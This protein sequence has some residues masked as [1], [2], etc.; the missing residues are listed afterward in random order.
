M[1]VK[2][3]LYV[4][5]MFFTVTKSSAVSAQ[6]KGISVHDP[7]I[8]KE[9]NT[10]HIFCTG[11]GI[12]H[13]YSGDLTHWI[14]GKPVFKKVPAWTQKVVPG[15]N[16]R[17]WAP[18]VSYYDGKYYLFYAVS[19]FG[20]NASAIGLAT[21]STLNE[22]SPEY[23]WKDQGIIV[24]SVPRRDMWNA[25]DPNLVVDNKGNPWLDF[26]SFWSG[27]KLVQLK[28]NRMGI[29][30]PQKWA[31]IASRKRKFG[32]ADT[33]PGNAAIEAPYIIHHGGYYYLFVSY[34]Y[35]CRGIKRNYK[36]MVGRAKEVTGPYTDKKGVPMTKG[37]AAVL[38]TGDRR[39]PGL[40]HNAVL[41]DHGK[42]Y[43]VFHAY[44]ARENG[45]PKL[46]ILPVS[47]E[48]GWPEIVHTDKPI[49]LK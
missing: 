48:N 37:G 22:R 46:R 47:W 18:D 41:S 19:A 15:F 2:Y 39:W 4:F 27:I 35:C 6:R 31:T 13:W 30:V 44:D 11:Y 3:L 38:L 25:I 12:T 20:K 16:G 26:G 14:R 21:N 9:G 23:Q 42:D 34:D 8:I 24:R 10:Y 36:M 5:L 40:G 17:I 49:V 43:L 1:L 45:K 29:K 28:K 32:L 33:L 7:C